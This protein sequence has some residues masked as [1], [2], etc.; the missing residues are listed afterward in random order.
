MRT[1]GRGRVFSTTIPSNKANL[2]RKFLIPNPIFLK[3]PHHSLHSIRIGNL[4]FNKGAFR[5]CSNTPRQIG[6]DIRLFLSN[7]Q[8]KHYLVLSVSLWLSAR[9]CVWIISP[10]YICSFHSPFN[11]FSKRLSNQILPPLNIILIYLSPPSS[12]LF[13]LSLSV[14][15]YE[16][17]YLSLSLSMSLWFTISL[18]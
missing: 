4:A 7:W 11:T 15:L 1:W 9:I 6:I 18:I 14:S 5:R 16:Y 12:P 13:S 8:T 3:V 17:I 10:S 2:N